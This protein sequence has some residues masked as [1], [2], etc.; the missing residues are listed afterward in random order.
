M[1]TSVRSTEWKPQAS[2]SKQ[3]QV[4]MAWIAEV[5][6]MQV[7]PASVV[8]A[9]SFNGCLVEAARHSGKDDQVI[10]DEI[11]ISHGYMSKFMRGVAQQ[12]ARRMVAFMRV[13]QSI[14]P[15]QWM[16]D[17]MGCDVALRS[18][19]LSEATILRARLAELERGGRVAA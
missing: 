3:T 16:A 10:A 2:G 13:T 6:S 12:W 14:A 19:A 15:L 9:A 7:I 11:F 1:S 17:Q 4:E 5:R 8:S 18:V